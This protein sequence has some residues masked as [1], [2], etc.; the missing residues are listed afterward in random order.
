MLKTYLSKYQYF[1]FAVVFALVGCSSDGGGDT[2]PTSTV[3]APTSVEGK[4]YVAT[5]T[6]GTGVYATTGKYTLSF[7]NTQPI[8]FAVGDGI[9]VASSSGTYTYTASGNSG[10][11]NFVD[12]LLGVGTLT[13]TFTTATSGTSLSTVASDPNST[14]TTTFVEL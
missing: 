13:F 10:T 5:I 7:S 8:Y 11:A 1:L 12:S 6:S 14:Q 2:T 3:T 4:V 9:T